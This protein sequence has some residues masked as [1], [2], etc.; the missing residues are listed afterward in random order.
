LPCCSLHAELV[1]GKGGGGL[2]VLLLLHGERF[3]IPIAGGVEVPLFLS[4]DA[5]LVIRGGFAP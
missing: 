2:V 1:I 5:E 4:D 3:E